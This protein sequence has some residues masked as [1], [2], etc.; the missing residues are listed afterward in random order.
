VAFFHS[1]KRLLILTGL[2]LLLT[3]LPFLFAALSNRPDYVF[4]GFLINTADGNSYLAKM[5]QGWAGSWTFTL[6]FSANPGEGTYIFLFYLFLGHLARGLGLPLL[7]VFHASRLLCGGA[8]I[9]ALDHFFRSTLGDDRLAWQA[10]LLASLGS[11]LGY[12]GLL[13]GAFTS[14]LWVAETYPFLATY[15]NPHFPLSLAI[16]LW[17]VSARRGYYTAW[18][19]AFQILGGLILA[20]LLPFGAILALLILGGEAGWD[21]LKTHRLAWQSPLLVFL[22]AAPVLLYQ[23]GVMTWQPALALWNA[24]NQT[25]SPP[26]WDVLLALSPALF[27]AVPGAV[28]VFR[29]G[30]GERL[31]LVI[32]ALLG[33]VLLYIP[34]SLQRRFMLGLYIPMAGLAVVGI[35]TFRQRFA[36]RFKRLFLAAL[37]L[38]LPSNLVVLAAG[39]FGVTSHAADI[40]L[41]ADED[42]AIH[43]LA[44]QPGNG[45]VLAGP[46][47]DLGLLLPGRTGKR[48]VY[49]H[50][51]ETIHAGVEKKGVADFFGGQLPDPQKYL[52]EQG[53]DFVLYVP[54]KQYVDPAVLAALKPALTLDTVTV[55][56]VSLPD[57]QA[58]P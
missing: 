54:A 22:G 32:W 44:D 42:R 39:A 45:L 35:E 23:Y 8:L 57:W 25:P 4:S 5:Y 47:P 37:L 29:R 52:V 19:I 56:R 46:D 12:L 53:V 51:F 26:P 9:F 38:S 55:Y 31:R 16:L 43:W 18:A 2:V 14:D 27:L 3:G 20:T 24:Q 1:N 58:A 34:F 10:T 30:K 48:V 28:S 36:G 15:S 50:P 41:T 17:L 21:W 49:G 40:F 11:G 7:V 13:A 33:L 6:P